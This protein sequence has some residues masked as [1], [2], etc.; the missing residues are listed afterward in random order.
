MK[1]D[2]LQALKTLRE[3][4]KV[5]GHYELVSLT[6]SGI[7]WGVDWLI[8][9]H[10]KKESSADPSQSYHELITPTLRQLMDL[11]QQWP[12]SS[13]HRYYP[14]AGREE[15]DE[16]TDLWENPLRVELLNWCIEQLESQQ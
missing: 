14:V 9:D 6:S 2:L 7:C 1:F 8:R 4:V 15:F 16:P 10:A 12:A 5:R 13:G 11:M 3:A